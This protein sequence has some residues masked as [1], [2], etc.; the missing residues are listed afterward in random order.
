MGKSLQLVKDLETRMND[1]VFTQ[2]MMKK[3]AAPEAKTL[4]SRTMNKLLCVLQRLS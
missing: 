4:N 1:L 2:S 3:K